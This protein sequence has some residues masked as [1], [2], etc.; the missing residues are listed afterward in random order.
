MESAI[1]NSSHIIFTDETFEPSWPNLQAPDVEVLILNIRSKNYMLPEFVKKMD[2][3]KALLITNYGFVRAEISNFPL[4]CSLLNLKRIRLEKVSI[5]S[6]GLSSLELRKLQKIS[7]VMCNIDQAFS[8]SRIQI[9]SSFSNLSEIS[10]DRCIDLK[11]LPVWFF[12]LV[13]LKKLSISSCWEL[14]ELPKEIGKLENLEVLRLHFCIQLEEVPEAIEKLSKL[15][16][17]DIS[18]CSNISHLPKQIGRLHNLRKLFMN[19][20]SISELPSSV[21]NLKRLEI[22]M[23]DEEVTI[24]WKSFIQRLPNLRIKPC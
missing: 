3:L 6:L 15:S 19:G 20:C 10:I 13:H 17:L 7:L 5:P 14:S 4:L 18:D 24:L 11:N 21:E 9:S 12:D 23:C 22:V 16:V 8:N 1:F 2:K